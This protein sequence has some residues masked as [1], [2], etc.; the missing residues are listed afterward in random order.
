MIEKYESRKEWLNKRGIG[1]TDAS[2]ILGKS[3][4]K[5]AYDI[6]NEHKYNKKAKDIDNEVLKRG[7]DSEKH[8]IALFQIDFPQY[9]IIDRTNT[10]YRHKKYPYLTGSLDAEIIDKENNRRGVYEAKTTD[11]STIYAN[12]IPEHYKI[13]LLHYLMITGFDFAVHDVRLRYYNEK[14]E[15][16]KTE[17]IRFFIDVDENVK[18]MINNLLIAEVE[19]YERYI[20]GDELPPI[21]L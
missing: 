18:I 3:P 11:R 8:I 9:E 5:N 12:G 10:I 15:I 19:F 7:R 16:Y 13:Q 2:A 17:Q 14:G 21:T 1:G 4:Y 6:V 20:L